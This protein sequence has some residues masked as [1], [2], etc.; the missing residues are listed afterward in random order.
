[1]R[2]HVLNT[3]KVFHGYVLYMKRPILLYSRHTQCLIH[4]L[5]LPHRNNRSSTFEKGHKK[6]H[7]CILNI[8]FVYAAKTMYKTIH[9]ENTTQ[10]SCI[11]FRRK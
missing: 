6:P 3:K 10:I 7:A 8:L 5:L 11:G 9:D 1:M 2:L 4:I